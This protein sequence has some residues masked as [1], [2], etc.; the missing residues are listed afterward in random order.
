MLRPNPQAGKDDT[1]NEAETFS[2][3]LAKVH[4]GGGVVS[5]ERLPALSYWVL[6][7]WCYV[8]RAGEIVHVFHRDSDC[9]D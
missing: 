9:V 6:G 4:L 7:R 2:G 3:G 1:V 5:P 8:N